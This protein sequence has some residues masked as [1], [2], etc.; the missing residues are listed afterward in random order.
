MNIP[1]TPLVLPTDARKQTAANAQGVARRIGVSRDAWRRWRRDRPT[2][3]DIMMLADPVGE[4]ARIVSELSE[5]SRRRF[6]AR[7]LA[8]AEAHDIPRETWAAELSRW[9]FQADCALLRDPDGT[10]KWLKGHRHEEASR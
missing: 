10:A 8:V 9:G 4:G 5:K 6:A 2:S 3:V 7:A 1:V